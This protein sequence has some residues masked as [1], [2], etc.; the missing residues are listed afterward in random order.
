LIRT[1]PRIFLGLL[2]P[3]NRKSRIECLDADL[4]NVGLSD[5]ESSESCFQKRRTKR[6][7]WTARPEGPPDGL[8]GSRGRPAIPRFK[9]P[10]DNG[11]INPMSTSLCIN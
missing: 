10:K 6:W 11:S 3:C 5:R 8:R 9:Y 2:I 4:R 1:I 7:Y